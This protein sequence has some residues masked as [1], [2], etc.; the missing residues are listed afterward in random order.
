MAAHPRDGAALRR[1]NPSFVFFREIAGDGP[2]GAERVVLT[3]GRS[4][5]SIAPSF[6]SGCRSG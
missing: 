5:P 4:W 2:L 6:R 3:A 1:D